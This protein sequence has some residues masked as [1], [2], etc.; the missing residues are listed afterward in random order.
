MMDGAYDA[1]L[2]IARLATAG[3][4]MLAL[5]VPG[6]WPAGYRS[7][8]PEVVRGYWETY[9]QVP[10]RL[11]VAAPSPAEI[12]DMEQALSWVRL[13]PEDR[14]VY[15]KLVLLRML[16]RPH[17]D[18]PIHSFEAIGAM[19]GISP[20]ALRNYYKDAISI[21]VGRLNAPGFCVAAGGQLGLQPGGVEAAARRGG[22]VPAR[23]TR[24]RT[25]EL[26]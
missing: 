22:A 11:R 3:R 2:V 14:V 16:Q 15:R 13:I 24:L 10:N 26:A 6:C 25:R 17:L 18:K 20:T 1:D 5:H 19:L 7:S 9:N 23:A 12:R 8:M 21:I 4:T